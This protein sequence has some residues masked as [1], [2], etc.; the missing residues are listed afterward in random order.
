MEKSLTHNILYPFR[1]HFRFFVV[2][3]PKIAQNE[4]YD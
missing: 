3:L 1:T 2:S 4:A